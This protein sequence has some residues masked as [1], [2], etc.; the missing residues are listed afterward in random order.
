MRTDST[1]DWLEALRRACA[2]TSQ[3]KVAARLHVSTTMV[4]QALAGKYRG[5]LGNLEARVRGELM[6]RTVDCPVLGEISLRRCQDEQRRPFATTNH[7]RVQLYLA[8]R[9]TCPHRREP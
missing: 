7:I 2:E 6:N 9:G 3:S 5:N 8:C 4:C 1:L